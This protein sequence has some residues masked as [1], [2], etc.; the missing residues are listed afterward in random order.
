MANNEWELKEVVKISEKESE[1]CKQPRY[2]GIASTIEA[3]KEANGSL[4]RF[5]HFAKTD[6]GKRYHAFAVPSFDN[7]GKPDGEY[8]F[9]E[10]NDKQQLVVKYSQHGTPKKNSLFV[11]DKDGNN[12]Y[13]KHVN[14]ETSFSYLSIDG[15]NRI[16]LQK[17]EEAQ[18][19]CPTGINIKKTIH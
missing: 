4:D 15:E 6:N 1:K 16:L 8:H 18:K 19:N 13:L 12:C 7:E 14:S 5:I 17:K 2:F 3:K 10:P 9:I 11:E